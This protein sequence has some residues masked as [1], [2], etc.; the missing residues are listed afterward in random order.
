[1]AR[2]LKVGFIGLG[3]MGLPLYRR[4][5]AKFPSSSCWALHPP[6]TLDHDFKMATGASEAVRE[7]NVIVTCLPNSEIVQQVYNDVQHTLTKESVWIDCTSGDPSVSRSLSEHS[8]L[9]SRHFLDCAVSGGPLGAQRGHL[10]AMVG[11]DVQAFDRSK[12]ILE[13]FARKIVYIGPSGTGH[14]VKAINNALLA[15]G[16]WSA[17]E[18]L[19]ALKKLGV[20]PSRALEAINSSSGRSWATMQRFPDHI[21]PR[22]FDYGFS[23]D[24]LKKD[25]ATAC[26]VLKEMDVPDKMIGKQLNLV[27][28]AIDHVG[29]TA[30]HLEIIKLLEKWSQACIEE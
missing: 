19:L 5:A 15:I 22:T 23:L 12:V 3:Q 9:N 30:D 2:S 21:V 28:Q 26:C 13:T 11:G 14:A 29:P 17:A 25:L 1:M 7:A 24:L 16:I 8:A 18:G 20:S 10:T 4:V 6:R 27:E